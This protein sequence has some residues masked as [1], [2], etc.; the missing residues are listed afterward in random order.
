MDEKNK[1]TSE[2]VLGPPKIDIV[3][4]WLT[5]AWSIIAGFVGS[6]IVIISIFFFLQNAQKFLWVYPY[7]YSITV[8]FAT[9][10]TAWLNIF[11]NKTINPDKYKRWSLTF[12]QVFLFSI[13]MFVFMLPVYVYATNIKQE[14]LVYIF[15]LHVVLSILASSIFSEL[16]SN[17]RYVLLWIYGSFIG[18]LVSILLTIIVFF[19]FQESSKNLYILI[20]LLIIINTAINSLRA[21][22]E[23]IYY[24][25]YSKTWMDQL[26]DIFYQIEQEEKEMVKKAKSELETFN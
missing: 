18:S 5:A 7:I 13:F 19:T 8:F 2:E 21:L 9:L 3:A 17:Y 1:L 10:F 4:V 23:Y 14:T 24:I 20:L 15:S 12:V 26:G 6:I 16:L 25:Y 22:F 11:L